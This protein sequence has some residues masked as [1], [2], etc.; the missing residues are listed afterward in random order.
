M[1]R[2]IYRTFFP[3]IIFVLF[4]SCA[5]TGGPGSSGLEEAV[6][7]AAL[8]IG[9]GLAPETRVAV[10]NIDAPD[11]KLAEYIIEEL[12]GELSK[13][14]SIVVISRKNISYIRD[15]LNYQTSMEVSDESAQSI[16][17]FLGA[18]L[19]IIG[20]FT[21]TGGAY[22][23]RLTA[24]NVELG[25]LVH[26]AE[27]YVPDNRA[28]KNLIR[29]LQ[30]GAQRTAAAPQDEII[31][32][33]TPG[34]FLNRGLTF[35][36]RGDYA[37]ATE[38]FSGALKLD[39]N[40]SLAYLQRGKARLAPL[41]SNVK[42]GKDSN[43]ELS[44]TVGKIAESNKAAAEAAIADFSQAIVIDPHLRSAYAYRGSAY[45]G[46]GD[47]DKAIDD[48]N[49]EIR[50]SPNYAYG[51]LDRGIA[52][53]NKGEYDSAIADYTQAIKLD[54]KF[55]LAYNNRGNAY[56]NKGDY[57]SAIVDC[58][59]SIKLD[60]NYA[61]AYN[62]RGIAYRNKGSYDKAIADYNQAIKVDPNFS[63]AYNNR[64][65]AYYCKGKTDRAIADY[66]QAIKV[67]PNDAG[68]YYN[69][70][71]AYYN[72]GDHDQAI[73]DYTQAIK[74]DPNYAYAYNGRG[75]TYYM[76]GDHDRAIDDYTQAI[77]LDHNYAD[78]YNNRGW[79]YYQKGDYNSAI[80]D[81]TEAL[82]IDPNHIKAQTNLEWARQRRGR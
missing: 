54:P 22:R 44:W 49:Q 23:F 82:R 71:N 43:F 28:L 47:D 37:L 50:I 51:Y 77:K 41:L 21:A 9:E 57:D 2:N 63:Y 6:K 56:N 75:F 58:T 73:D 35:A 81:F 38:D 8:E 62:N 34:D 52:Y 66:N 55:S 16:G 4:F 68:V 78:A 13:N 1:F 70:G 3:A 39:Q 45:V 72:K 30:R 19:I 64:G 26:S 60:P 29:A 11:P 17:H 14:K 79:T 18:Q 59:Q 31:I 5:T 53:N 12:N 24:N 42:V 80:D 27:D 32:P 46:L 10:V 48:F 15:E 74:V 67:D 40:F 25:T 65:F 20:S 61:L 7:Q 36:L 76:K 33:R 69:R